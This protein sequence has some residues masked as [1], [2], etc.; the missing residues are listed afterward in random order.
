MSFTQRLWSAAIKSWGGLITFLGFIAAILA[1]F[2]TPESDFVPMNVFIVCVFVAM[3]IIGILLRAAFEASSNSTLILPK[4][5][6][7]LDAPA[8]YKNYSALFLVDPSNFLSHDSTV[9]IYSIDDDFEQFIGLGVVINVQNDKK[10]QIV[11]LNAE[12][13]QSLIDSL[14]S[15][16][17][18]DLDRLVL[19]PTIPKAFLERNT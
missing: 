12:D 5:R 14:K 19:K 15:N 1:F 7:I 17:R 11:V 9:S 16:K 18:H 4:V 8:G 3:I 13:S 10:I 2:V 6:K